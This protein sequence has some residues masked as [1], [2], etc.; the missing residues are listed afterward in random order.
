MPMT[1]VTEH[2]SVDDI[3]LNDTKW[4]KSCHNK[5]SQDRLD[6]AQKRKRADMEA[7]SNNV[8]CARQIWPRRQSL[9][10]SKCILVKKVV[11]NFISLVRSNWTLMYGVWPETLK[12]FFL[13]Q[14]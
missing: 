14:N 4:H 11:V 12:C 7:E 13:C 6:R 9:D 5:F 8:S 1:D 2:V 3:C 10:K